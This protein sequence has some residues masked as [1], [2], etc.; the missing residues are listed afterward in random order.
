[1]I[2]YFSK[3][4]P[5]LAVVAITAVLLSSCGGSSNSEYSLEADTISVVEEATEDSNARKYKLSL[6]GLIEFA[7]INCIR[8]ETRNRVIDFVP[9]DLQEHLR[10]DR[11]AHVEDYHFGE[12]PYEGLALFLFGD[13]HNMD[14]EHTNQRA[15]WLSSFMDGEH[16]DTRHIL[17]YDASICGEPFVWFKELDGT[18]FV[19]VRKHGCIN[20]ALEGE[21]ERYIPEVY[22]S[23][24]ADENGRLDMMPDPFYWMCIQPHW[25]SYPEQ[26]FL[27]LPRQGFSPMERMLS[28]INSSKTEVSKNTDLCNTFDYSSRII[29]DSINTRAQYIQYTVLPDHPE[30]TPTLHEIKV[31]HTKP[32]FVVA[33]NLF[34]MSNGFA[35]QRLKFYEY[36]P[37]QKVITGLKQESAINR[38]KDS[39]F[40]SSTQ[41]ENGYDCNG[42]H[43]EYDF[44]SFI[45]G[46]F[47]VLFVTDGCDLDQTFDFAMMRFHNDSVEFVGMY[48]DESWERLGI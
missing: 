33:K 32:N 22:E 36:D 8:R 47:K 27:S 45:N 3:V 28:L 40:L 46:Y 35:T 19:E 44:Q 17:S 15:F 20:Q 21:P 9:F 18:Y 31:W 4:K 34:S 37:Q 39:D 38:L 12:N 16:V 7:A 48:T 11:L 29:I 24:G 23:W 30:M 25:L 10:I 1:M 26:I 43:Y 2:L 5:Y 14:V 6:K 41:Y 42:A 13:Y